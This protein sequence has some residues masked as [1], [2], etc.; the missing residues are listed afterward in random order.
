LPLT[1]NRYWQGQ[2]DDFGERIVNDATR[3]CLT[4]GSTSAWSASCNGS[5]AQQWQVIG[6]GLFRNVQRATCLQGTTA[7]GGIFM[8]SCNQG[9]RY[10]QWGQ[11]DT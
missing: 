4:A 8:A 3:R 9:N 5:T 7:G 2:E 6:A 11:L 1:G 10:Q